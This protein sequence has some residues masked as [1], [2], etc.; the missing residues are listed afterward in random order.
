MLNENQM[1]STVASKKKRASVESQLLE[2]ID[3]LYRG[4]L[5]LSRDPHEAEDLVQEVC[6]KAIRFSDKFQ[7]GTNI[8]A[9]LFKILCALADTP[10]IYMIVYLVKDRF[11]VHQE[12]PT[13]P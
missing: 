11:P 2:H 7:P 8:R 10:I 13:E 6:L 1:P 5:R 12:E 4:A 3:S 9:W